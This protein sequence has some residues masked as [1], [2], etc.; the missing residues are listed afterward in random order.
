M[1]AAEY[2]NLIN[3]R[4]VDLY[5]GGGNRV[6]NTLHAFLQPLPNKPVYNIQIWYY[7]LPL[8]LDLFLCGLA[9]I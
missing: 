1:P 6:S 5:M 7:N 4:T 2:D 9:Y 3:A 8:D